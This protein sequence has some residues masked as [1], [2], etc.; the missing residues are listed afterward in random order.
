VE[1]TKPQWVFNLLYLGKSYLAKGD[2]DN[3]IKFL[4]QAEAVNPAN[5]AEREATE[6]AKGLVR[7]HTK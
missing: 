3:A 6:E 5:D 4:K 2:K 7:K 1:K